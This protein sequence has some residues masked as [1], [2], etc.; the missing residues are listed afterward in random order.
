MEATDDEAKLAY[1]SDIKSIEHRLIALL[2]LSR[3]RIQG[4]VDALDRCLTLA[5]RDPT[6]TVAALCGILHN[7][8]AGAVDVQAGPLLA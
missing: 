5:D 2:G 3:M 8:A 1:A 4:F 6:I 7:R